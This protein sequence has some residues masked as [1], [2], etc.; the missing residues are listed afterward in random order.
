MVK[1]FFREMKREF[2]RI[3]WP[4]NQKLLGKSL[5]VVLHILFFTTV[6]Y[7]VDTFLTCISRQ[8]FG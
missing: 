3:T 6:I 8:I 2:H 5:S 7:L 4:S 1:Q